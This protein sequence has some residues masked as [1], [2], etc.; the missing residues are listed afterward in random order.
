MNNGGGDGDG[1]TSVKECC[2]LVL[3]FEWHN[4]VLRSAAAELVLV[5]V[6]AEKAEAELILLVRGY[7]AVVRVAEI[8]NLCLF[9]CPAEIGGGESFFNDDEGSAPLPS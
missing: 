6:A 9:G 8:M 5:G 3:E 1:V 7:T 2:C 4:S